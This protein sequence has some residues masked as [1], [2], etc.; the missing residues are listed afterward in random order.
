MPHQPLSWKPEYSVNDAELDEHHQHM[1]K[2]GNRIL[3][4][5]DKTNVAAEELLQMLE[6]L[7]DHV[8]YHFDTEEAYL[9]KMDYPQIKQHLFDHDH[10]RKQ[11]EEFIQQIR[12][13]QKSCTTDVDCHALVE[14][15]ARFVYAWVSEHMMGGAKSERFFAQKRQHS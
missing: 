8:F 15:V 7:K 4:L 12:W 2:I 5:A 13:Q 9:K 10:Y 3:D 1:V 6:E 14:R 11:I